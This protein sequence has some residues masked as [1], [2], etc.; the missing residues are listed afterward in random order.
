MLFRS[1]QPFRTDAGV[2]LIKVE[3]HV[4]AG[5]NS[6]GL[7]PE[8]AEGI[9]RKLYNEALR[10]RYERWFQSELRFRHQVDNFLTGSTNSPSNPPLKS[11]RRKEET[12]TAAKE[13]EQKSF[14]QRLLPF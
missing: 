12:V 14:F 13:P 8:T 9:K 2:H 11:A 6:T 10:D 7:D 5:Q 4:A 3:E 1:S